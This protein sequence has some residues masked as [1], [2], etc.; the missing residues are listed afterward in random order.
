[1]ITLEKA[2]TLNSSLIEFLYENE[3]VEYAIIEKLGAFQVTNVNWESFCI[4][5]E[6]FKKFKRLYNELEY[7]TFSEVNPDNYEVLLSFLKANQHILI[8]EFLDL[9]EMSGVIDKY[10]DI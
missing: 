8:Q 9:K 6:N 3:P 7:P 1:M 5:Q 2:I 10:C 4:L